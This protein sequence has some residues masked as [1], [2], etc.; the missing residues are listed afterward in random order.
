[1]TQSEQR[2]AIGFSVVVIIGGA[3]IGFTQLKNWKQRVDLR[4]YDIR[5]QQQEANDL[6]AQADVWEAR[7]TWLLEKLP[8]FT[9]R[10]EADLILLNL[11]RDSSSQH[12]IATQTQPIQPSEKAGMVSASMAVEAKGE[13]SNI[14]KWLHSIQEPTSFIN[15]PTLTMLNNEENPDEVIVNLTVQKWFRLPP[16]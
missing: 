7:S 1:M 15:V 2:L 4:T 10:G 13:L 9:K 6:I 5:A 3:F 14:L 11:V 16:S 12:S 8:P